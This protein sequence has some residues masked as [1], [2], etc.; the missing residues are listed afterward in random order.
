ME[1]CSTANSS[2]FHLATAPKAALS[3]SRSQSPDA[4][5]SLVRRS[6]VP[7]STSVANGLERVRYFSRQL[8][9]AE[10]MRAE[11]EYFINKQRRHNRLLHG[12]GVVCGLDVS[13][14]PDTD[15]PQRVAVSAGYALTPQGDE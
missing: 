11:Q 12:T 15:F 2:L 13:A 6:P 14:S 5:L 7:S 9:T 10:D 3:H 4:N 1:V 8:I